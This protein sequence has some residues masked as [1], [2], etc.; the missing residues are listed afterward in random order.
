MKAR[1]ALRLLSTTRGAQVS[2]TLTRR[3]STLLDNGAS[4]RR[5]LVGSALRALVLMGAIGCGVARGPRLEPVRWQ[6]LDSLLRAAVVAGDIPGAVVLVTS[7]NRIVYERAVGTLDPASG[8]SLSGNA[9]FN[10]ASMTKPI[11]SVAAMML[12]DEGKI[13]L[14]APASRYLP[15]LKDRQLLVRVDSARGAAVTKPATREITVR[16]LLRHTSGFGY[17]FSNTD[18]RALEKHTTMTDRAAPLLHEPGSQWTY[19]MGTA[20][21]GWIIEHVS[22]MPLE[23]FLRQRL[24]EPL[25]MEETSFSLPAS[26][27]VRLMTLY[28][29]RDGKL[30]ARARPDSIATEGRGDG[31]LHLTAKDY[32]LFLQFMLGDGTWGRKRLL[33]TTSMQAMMR[34]QLGGLTVT[35]QPSAMP[36]VSAAFPLGAGRDGFGLG[37]QVAVRSPDGR[38]DGT[39]SWS[40]LFNT[41]FWIDRTTGIGVLFMTQVLPFYDG[42]VMGVVR[43]VERT[44]YRSRGAAP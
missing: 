42:R 19:G 25:G 30:V 21:V 17:S 7:R 18:L 36:G 13:D 2:R 8:R 3:W 37:F 29:R 31:D 5:A 15:E 40:G 24:F 34:D 27:A 11:T 38:P 39:L 28:R 26:R 4:C 35:E 43:A 16:D 33:R 32:A 22:G 44:I 20:H 23:T 10:I 6:P 1:D 41:H 9:V 12:V 14:D